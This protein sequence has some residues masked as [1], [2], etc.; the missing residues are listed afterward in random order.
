LLGW[1]P[2][3]VEPSSFTILL[4]NPEENY[5]VNLGEKQI[6]INA[7][8]VKF[9]KIKYQSTHPNTLVM[10]LLS[11]N[12]IIILE[13]EYY[14]V[15][16]GFIQRK[17]EETN[18]ENGKI[19][20]FPFSTMTEFKNHLS[21]NKITLTELMLTNESDVSGLSRKEIYHKIDNILE[22]MHRAVKRGLRTKGQLPGS[23][24]LRRKAPILYEEA[25][26]HASAM[27]SFMIFLNAYCMAASEENAAGSIVVTAPTSGASGV[28][29]GI[30]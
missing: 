23:I 9:E 22:F 21:K 16:G 20:T 19:P 25:K 5:F 29:P 3:T 1:L 15:G 11:K 4:K 8:S 18:T 14:S 24:K 12:E 28:I 13:E 17:G 7:K 2:D 30:Y 27:D 10:R 6:S 26:N